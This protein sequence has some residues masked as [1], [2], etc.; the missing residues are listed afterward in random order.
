MTVFEAEQDL[1]D[2]GTG[3]GLAG[4]HQGQ[5]LVDEIRAEGGRDP[6]EGGDQVLLGRVVDARQVVDD[7][8]D[9]LDGALVAE[10]PEGGGANRRVVVIDLS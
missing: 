10:V 1:D 2:G 8:I 4:G 5:Q 6:A 7:E 9:R 3:A